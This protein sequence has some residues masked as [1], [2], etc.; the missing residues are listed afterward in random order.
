MTENCM[1]ETCLAE[2]TSENWDVVIA[3]G[4]AAGLSAALTLGRSLRRVAVVDAGQPRNRFAAH[5][6]SVLGH[7]GLDPVELLRKGR[8]EAASYGVTFLDGIVSA[9]RADER[10][11]TVVTGEDELT[12]RALVVATGLT[13]DLPEL[14]GLT[15]R[16][17][18]SVLHCP[19]CH[20][21]EV[22]GSRIGV[23]GSSPM[24]SHQAELVRQWTDRLTYFTAGTTD[25]GADLDPETAARLRARGV[26]L[27]GTP[28][29]EV[30]GEDDRLTGVLL[31]DGRQ[32]PLDALFAAPV[33]RPHD[34]FLADLGLKRVE[35]PMGSFLATDPT[36]RTS[37]PWIWAIGNVVNPGANVPISI[38]AGSL[39][40]AMVNLALVSEEF[41]DAMLVAHDHVP[42]VGLGADQ[43]VDL[44]T[45]HGTDLT[46][47]HGAGE[48]SPEEFWEN[49][50]TGSDQVW[51]G[52]VNTTLADV[53][54]DLPVGDV[55]D[56]GC[57]EGGDAVWLAEQGWRVTA[58]DISPTA[59]GRGVE[60]ARSRGVADR[61]TWIAHDLASWRT[62]RKFDLVTASFF[63]STVELPRTEILR[64]VAER[65]RPGGRLLLI[66]HV[67]ETEEDI[68]PWAWQREAA[69]DDATD[70]AGGHA[71]EPVLLTPEDEIAELALTGWRPER[72]EILRREATGPDG[73]QKAMLKDGLV[74]LRRPGVGKEA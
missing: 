43:G 59:V 5:M 27:I 29:S 44:S 22:R 41:D 73:Q 8:E 26:Q 69:P 56:L 9:V 54:K 21:W 47:D 63:H 70:A 28:V 50:Y 31:A 1:T 20:G 35:N 72:S 34:G 15:E 23:L 46:A 30:L 14:P 19:Y 4:G 55:L 25:A 51:S 3:G 11:V 74:L 7:E 2:S 49:R 68:P 36:G 33:S 58:V 67:F 62:E 6:H 16:W 18:T 53:V 12:A 66:S 40:G 64:R 60:G 38:G 52:R 13:D 17:G 10:T 57:G 45:G 65:V 71:H 61:V 24:S 39:T 42:D 37:H 32:V 48:P